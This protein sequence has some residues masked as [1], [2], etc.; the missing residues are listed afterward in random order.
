MNLKLF[1]D[2][3]RIISKKIL[4]IKNKDLQILQINA[5]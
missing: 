5:L 4:A 2:N 1:F 3:F